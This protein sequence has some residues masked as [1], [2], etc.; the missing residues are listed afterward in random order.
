MNRTHLTIFNQWLDAVVGGRSTLPTAASEATLQ[1]VTSAARQLHDLAYQA[2]AISPHR[3]L[4]P[5]WEEFMHAHR[6]DVSPPVTTTTPSSSS[7]KTSQNRSAAVNVLN[8]R[9]VRLASNILLAAIVLAVL[10]AGAWRAAD[11]FRP[12]PP[13]EP[14]TIP[15]GAFIQDEATPDTAPPADLPTAADC[16]VEPLT[17]DEVIWYITDPYASMMTSPD[18]EPLANFPYQDP[19]TPPATNEPLGPAD[20]EDLDEMVATQ[21]MWM[22]CVLADS[23]FQVWATISPDAVGRML[24]YTFPPLTGEEEAREML[25]ALETGTWESDPPIN[26]FP[27]YLGSTCFDIAV[28]SSDPSRSYG[29]DLVAAVPEGTA[30]R[31]AYYVVDTLWSD[32]PMTDTGY[33]TPAS[34]DRMEIGLQGEANLFVFRWND[35]RQAWMIE[36][37]PGC[38]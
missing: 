25:E 15:F 32:G 22:A 7:S 26:Y 24:S 30:S 33:A 1:E 2:D 23:P 36:S 3:S 20:Q 19:A 16:T 18:A 5:T 21:R 17:V 34:A 6:L 31:S 12:A 10:V 38:G 4:P 35:A 13:E 28:I 37:W 9:P 27:G 8:G 11:T 29:L 14:S